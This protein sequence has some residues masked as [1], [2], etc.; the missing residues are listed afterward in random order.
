MIRLRLGH[1]LL[2]SLGLLAALAC[3]GEDL[4]LPPN[5]SPSGTSAGQLFMAAGNNQTGVAGAALAEPVMVQLVDSTGH[6]IADQPVSWVV[7]T[8]GGSATPAA[9]TTDSG[10]FAS[11]TRTLGSA[12]SNSLSAV[13]SGVGMVTFTATVHPSNDLLVGD[14]FRDTQNGIAAFDL[15]ITES[16]QY[17][18]R[19]LSDELPQLG[20]HGPEP[21]L[22]SDPFEVR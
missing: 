2:P 5:G 6:G 13:V 4:V 10:G 19:A 11:A 16:D 15:R 3:G 8:G 9:P 7:N 1:F 14:R 17:R 20:P 18:L 22:Y 21:W 12:G